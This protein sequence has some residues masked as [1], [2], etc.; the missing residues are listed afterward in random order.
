MSI[1]VWIIGDSWGDA[2][3]TLAMQGVKPSQGLEYTI[4]QRLGIHTQDVVNPVVVV[5]VTT[6]HLLSLRVLYARVNALPH[7]SYSFG[8]SPYVIGVTTIAI[9]VPIGV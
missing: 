9:A 2:W 1:K 5:L 6:M 3:G 4:A 8:L 7:T